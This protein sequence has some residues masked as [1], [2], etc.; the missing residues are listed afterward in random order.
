MDTTHG[1]RRSLASTAARSISIP[2]LVGA[3]LGAVA[4]MLLPHSGD[5]GDVLSSTPAASSS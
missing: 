4:A 5:Q 1:P 2:A 3:S